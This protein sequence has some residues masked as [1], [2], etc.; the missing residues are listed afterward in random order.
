V[1]GA[2]L[3]SCSVTA[4]A[5]VG[6]RS[7]ALARG[8]ATAGPGGAGTLRVGLQPTA[9]GRRL[10]ARALGGR[11]VTLRAD[12]PTTAQQA[13][14]ATAVARLYPHRQTIAPPLAAGAI[15]APD[16][17]LPTS[18]GRRFLARVA[19][20]L[21]AVSAVECR[22]HVAPGIEGL[23]GSG[24]TRRLGR[25]RGAAACAALRR[26]GLK[27]RTTVVSAGKRRPRVPDDGG[28]RRALNRSVTLVVTRD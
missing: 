9:R 22:G 19:A 12:A 26:H 5:R 8:T 18:A 20:R 15:F 3:R 28:G 4:S 23:G 25:A 14:A 24:S 7:V 1:T 27:A 10:V 2:L 13:L 17:P 6:G 16:S 11:R 21:R